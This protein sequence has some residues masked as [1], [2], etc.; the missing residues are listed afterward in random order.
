MLQQKKIS[1]SK[2]EQRTCPS[3]AKHD[4][5]YKPFTNHMKEI[6]TH[7]HTHTHTYIYR[8]RL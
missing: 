8:K 2:E 5:E 1:K 6:N 3:K 4:K 7:T